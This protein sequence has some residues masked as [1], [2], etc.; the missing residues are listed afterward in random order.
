MEQQSLKVEARS[1]TGKGICRRL[2][3][4]A[5]VPGVVYGRGAASVPVSMDLKEL[6]G[7]MAAGKNA[8][9]ALQGGS[10]DGS[11]VIISA[12]TRHKM[13]GV[14]THVDLHKVNL[15]EKV[16]VQVPVKLVGVA[17]GVKEGGLLDF[18]M[19]TIDLECLPGQIPEQ[20]DVDIT[21][22]AIGHSLHVGDLAV[23]AGLKLLSDPKGTVVSVLGK[24]REETPAAE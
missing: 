14:P 22:L 6:Q 21:G 2:R 23:P 15:A 16:H 8:L 5:R 1:G 7:V 17:A 12:V 10:L 24:V 19:H 11:T 20:I 18:A 13:K 4:E 3:N 9:V